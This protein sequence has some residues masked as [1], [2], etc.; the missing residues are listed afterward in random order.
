MSDEK[1]IQPVQGIGEEPWVG[2]RSEKDFAN[3]THDDLIHWN[4]KRRQAD[5]YEFYIRAFDLQLSNKVDGDYFE[6]GC[7]R[8]RTFRMA[9]TEARR[10]FMDHMHFLA[11]DSFQGLPECENDVD[12]DAYTPGA[13]CTSEDDFMGMINDHGIYV[14]KVQTHKGFYNESLTGELQEKLVAEGRKASIVCVD[15]DLFSSARDVFNFI[16]PFMQPGTLVYLDDM[17]AGYKGSP[18]R[19]VHGAFVEF[20]EASPYDFIEY[21]QV[22]C[23]GRA[24]IAYENKPRI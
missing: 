15:C 5:K 9:L 11:F 1:D 7:H 16:G 21:A 24:F 12:V 22:G 2:L 10:R 19:G 20:K 14:N 17:F 23:F 4:Q 13:L 3:W 18:I 6:F 8:A